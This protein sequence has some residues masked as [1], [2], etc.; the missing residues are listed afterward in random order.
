MVMLAAGLSGSRGF[1]SRGQSGGREE[2]ALAEPASLG[3]RMRIWLGFWQRRHL[4]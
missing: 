3:R 4:W 1:G 2:G